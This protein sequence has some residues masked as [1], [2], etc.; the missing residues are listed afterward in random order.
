MVNQRRQLPEV[1]CASW[2]DFVLNTRIYFG[3]SV[4]FPEN[5]DLDVFVQDEVVTP[6][7]A[8]RFMMNM[9]AVAKYAVDNYGCVYEELSAPRDT[10]MGGDLQYVE[11]VRDEFPVG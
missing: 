4:P 10:P 9:A 5:S 1:V 6:L 7:L 11:T 3:P 2:T 8:Y